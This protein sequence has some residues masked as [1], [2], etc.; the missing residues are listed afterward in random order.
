M[1]S[2]AREQQYTFF[3]WPIEEQI[4]R[5][6]PKQRLWKQSQAGV[7]VKL[8]LIFSTLNNKKIKFRIIELFLRTFG[9]MQQV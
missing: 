8:F 5:K 9:I 2:K 4:P 6:Q 3:I 1:L 7:K